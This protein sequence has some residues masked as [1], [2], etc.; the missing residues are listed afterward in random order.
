MYSKN[1]LDKLFE[2]N[3]KILIVIFFFISG[4]VNGIFVLYFF[5]LLF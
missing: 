3:W 2:K 1:I 4:W 5:F